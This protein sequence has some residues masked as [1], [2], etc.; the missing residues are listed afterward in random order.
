MQ[1]NQ[2]NTGKRI[3]LKEAIKNKAT[4]P[5]GTYAE[6]EAKNNVKRGRPPKKETETIYKRITINCTKSEYEQI[7]NKIEL[8]GEI[9]PGIEYNPTMLTKIAIRRY[10][11]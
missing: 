7:E 3:D 6:V 11:K 2:N 1:K 8:L 9:T 4:T 5:Q 10:V